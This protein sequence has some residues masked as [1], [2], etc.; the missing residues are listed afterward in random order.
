MNEISNPKEHI[1][2]EVNLRKKTWLLCGSYNPNKSL[3][4]QHLSIISKDLDTLLARYDN[5]N[6]FLIG[7]FNVDKNDASLKTFC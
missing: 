7:D 6:N 4:S 3:I 5:D 1:F 2:I